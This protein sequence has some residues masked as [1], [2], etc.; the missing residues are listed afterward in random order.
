MSL[1]WVVAGTLGQ[2]IMGCLLFM[3]VVFSGAGIANAHALSKFQSVFL[4]LSIYLLPFSCLLSAGIVIY[5]YRSGAGAASYWWYTF[6]LLLAVV[7]L[8]F[9]L[10][11]AA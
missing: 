6:P 5:L 4:S 2:L 10:K 11:L 8:W 7:Y 9:A 3:L 1:A